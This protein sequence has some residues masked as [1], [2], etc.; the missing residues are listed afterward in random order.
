MGLGTTQDGA[1]VLLERVARQ[2]DRLVTAFHC[3]YETVRITSLGRK[4]P[5]FG[6][7][8][9]QVGVVSGRVGFCERPHK[10]TEKGLVVS[11]TV[12]IVRIVFLGDCGVRERVEQLSGQLSIVFWHE[13]PKTSQHD[14]VVSLFIFKS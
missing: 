6:K 10:V 4:W 14:G 11:S 2:F 8:L 1:H 7:L 5:G 13:T 9:T 3:S 12:L